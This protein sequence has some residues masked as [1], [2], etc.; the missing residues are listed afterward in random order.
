MGFVGS[1][2]DPFPTLPPLLLFP[3]I[4][5]WHFLIMSF[6]LLCSSSPLLFSFSVW[7]EELAKVHKRYDPTLLLFSPI[8]SALPSISA[9]YCRKALGRTL[10]IP[11]VPFRINSCLISTQTDLWL[12]ECGRACPIFFE[13]NT[14]TTDMG[15]TCV[16]DV[17]AHTTGSVWWSSAPC[18]QKWF[19]SL[20][21]LPKTIP[22]TALH[23][24]LVSRNPEFVSKQAQIV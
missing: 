15:H 10:R 11:Q 5:P 16:Q 9:W 2:A 12:Q 13:V 20:L 23:R 19:L 17:T 4:F 6:L 22:S 7:W 24:S 21:V 18:I 14:S 8:F 3:G 1:Q